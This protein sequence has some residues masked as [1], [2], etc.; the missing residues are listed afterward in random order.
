MAS[1]MEQPEEISLRDINFSDS[2]LDE[3]TD[4][5]TE[6]GP[7]VS[8]MKV[9]TSWSR[10]WKVATILLGALS[11]M[12]LV[13]LIAII[14]LYESGDAGNTDQADKDGTKGVTTDVTPDVTSDVKCS[15]GHET[16]TPTVTPPP[17]SVTLSPPHPS[18]MPPT[19]VVPGQP[20]AL[21]IPPGEL[22][23]YSME[24][25]GLSEV[26][27]ELN[28]AGD[29]PADVAVYG[30]RGCTPT[31]VVY[32]VVQT[33]AASTQLRHTAA[34]AKFNPW[35]CG[36]NHL[37][38]SSPRDC[39]NLRT[40]AGTERVSPAP[41]G[42]STAGKAAAATQ[43]SPI[44]AREDRTT[45]PTTAAGAEGGVCVFPVGPDNSVNFLTAFR[46][47]VTDVVS[48]RAGSARVSQGGEEEL[49][50]KGTASRRTAMAMAPVRKAHADV[51]M[52][53]RASRVTHVCIKML[54]IQRD[55][56]ST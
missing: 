54:S 9:S 40:V 56:H 19:G 48:A 39:V 35:T 13:A 4:R 6:L 17:Q 29:V 32:D 30:C 25:P 55:A 18:D 8:A 31:H 11:L 27:L 44:R 7:D 38:G 49:V 24:L 26:S 47:T 5:R 1:P 3:K 21:Q 50:K 41:V 14:A 16:P 12:L 10:R 46:G 2:N 28:T 51:F 37:V 52:G 45:V 53:G 43:L 36:Q 20:V 33:S 42:V 15:T 22:G 23:F 34:G